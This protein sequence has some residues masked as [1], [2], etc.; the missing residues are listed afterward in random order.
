MS[1]RKSISV[2][3][4]FLVLC[5]AGTSF[6]QTLDRPGLLAKIDFLRNQLHSKEAQFL[7]PSSEDFS[8][9][10]DFL[11]KPDTGLA[12]LMPREKYDGKL[13]LR[14]GGAYYSFV[15]KTNEYGFGSDL[16]FEQGILRV[17]LAGADF[18][19]LTALGDFPIDGVNLDQPGVQYLAGFTAPQSEA[20]AREQYGRSSAGFQVDGFNYKSNLPAT[21][22]QTYALRS[23]LYSRSDVL[24]VFRI[25]RQDVD[26][27]LILAWRMLKKFVEPRLA[28]S[29][30]N[31]LSAI[32]VAS[33]ENRAVLE[34]E[35]GNLLADLKSTEQQF[36]APSDND[37]A[38]YSEF[39]KLPNTGLIRLLPRE[40]FQ[41]RLTIN[42]G[43]AYYSFA[44]RT[45]EYGFGSDIELSNNQFSVGFAGADFGFITRL[46]KVSIE[47]ISLT[48]PAAQFLA[49]FVAPKVD[50]EAR[51]QYRRAQAGFDANG[52]TYRSAFSLKKKRAYLLRSINYRDSDLLIAFRIVSQDDDGSVV[53]VWKI[54]KTFD[55]PQLTS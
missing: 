17:G 53:I 50:A 25:A 27:S 19:F 45:H 33:D 31:Q 37:R 6:A 48:D 38:K 7:A 36:L 24:V 28:A 55:I 18:G 8:S 42:G 16:Q 41:D 22:N 3:L 26:G 40:T 23:I 20:G 47:D 43:A 12:R 11:S 30:V 32:R 49:S 52:F 9:F 2:L 13:L 15:M 21:V 29:S 14:G 4:S 34:G 54:L 44:R 1:R 10:A 51:D 35:I 46:G 39:L 5:A